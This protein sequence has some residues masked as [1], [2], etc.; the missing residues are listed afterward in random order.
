MTIKP[1]SPEAHARSLKAAETRKRNKELGKTP[2]RAKG[3][4]RESVKGATTMP[5]KS[6]ILVVSCPK[7]GDK[8]PLSA[9]RMQAHEMKERNPSKLDTPIACYRTGCHGKHAELVEAHKATL[10]PPGERKPRKVVQYK[11]IAK[12]VTPRMILD[13]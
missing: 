9:F 10:T 4:R 1:G 7:C 2:T 5:V 6:R 8:R 11:A 13:L 3:T 12:R